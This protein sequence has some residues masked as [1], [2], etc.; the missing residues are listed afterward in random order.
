[1]GPTWDPP[2][3]DRTQVGP[4]LA[5]WT[6]LSGCF[7]IKT[8]FPGIQVPDINVRRRENVSY[9]WWEFLYLYT[10]KTVSLYWECTSISE[11]FS[12]VMRGI[13][14][15]CKCSIKIEWFYGWVCHGKL[16]RL[17]IQLKRLLPE[18]AYLAS[19]KYKWIVFSKVGRIYAC[20]KLYF[21]RGKIYIS[22]IHDDVIKWKHFF[23]LQTLCEGNPPVS[24]G[25]HSHRLV[26]RSFDI[27]FDLRLNKRLSKRSR[28][29]WFA[30][31][32]CSLW[33]HCNIYIISTG[34]V[35]AGSQTLLSLAQFNMLDMVETSFKSY[36][37]HSSLAK[38][39]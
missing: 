29:Q 14:N 36:I 2:G 38:H 6:L 39:N 16:I 10:H 22:S 17:C 9:L 19:K 35:D 27:S 30:M 3:A 26:T 25:F 32:S 37:T 23:A 13:H 31:V 28:H 12:H 34:W 8:V 1:M 4:I 5:P 20:I 15:D 18:W 24:G 7:Y 21:P 11:W 33:R